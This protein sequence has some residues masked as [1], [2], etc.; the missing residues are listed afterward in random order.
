MHMWTG[1]KRLDLWRRPPSSG[2]WRH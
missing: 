2:Q 1:K